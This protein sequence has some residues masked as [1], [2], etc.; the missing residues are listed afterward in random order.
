MA[1][2]PMTKQKLVQDV[3]SRSPRACK[4]MDSLVAV[5]KALWEGDCGAVPVVDDSGRIAGMITDR[6][7]LMAAF[8]RGRKLEDLSVQSAMAH[9][10]F[11]VRDTETAESALRRMQEHQVRR[12][13]VVDGNGSLCGMVS[14][15]DLCASKA[16][17]DPALVAAAAA[18]IAAPRGSA[19]AKTAAAQPNPV[20]APKVAAPT[21]EKAVEQPIDK[22]QKKKG[23]KRI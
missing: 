23:G 6:D 10:V 11:S 8:T 2:Q 16:A 9:M 1:S 20:P 4:R 21:P 19:G 18:G 14:F 13:P 12:L 15:A 22:P 5:A 3:M 7:C 17:L